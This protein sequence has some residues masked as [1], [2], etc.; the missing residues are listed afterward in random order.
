MTEKLVDIR[1]AGDRLL[2]VFPVSLENRDAN[3]AA[4]K[5]KALE[6]AGHAGLSPGPD[7]PPLIAEKR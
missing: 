2:H 7:A 5:E 4:F 1:N 6:S 3:D